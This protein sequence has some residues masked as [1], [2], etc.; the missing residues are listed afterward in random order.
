MPQGVYLSFSA[1][2]GSHNDLVLA[3]AIA[4]ISVFERAVEVG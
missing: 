4:L 3:V 2:S 1:R